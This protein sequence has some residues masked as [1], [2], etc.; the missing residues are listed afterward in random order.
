MHQSYSDRSASDSSSIVSISQDAPD[1]IISGPY[2]AASP[3]NRK[4][5]PLCIRHE[6]SHKLDS[7]HTMNL[8]C[9]SSLP[10]R[11][12]VSF[13]CFPILCFS[14]LFVIL[15]LFVFRSFSS[16]SQTHLDTLNPTSPSAQMPSPSF[17]SS[18]SP[19]SLFTNSR[20]PDAFRSNASL[21]PN[22]RPR[23]HAMNSA[24]QSDP[25]NVTAQERGNAS[26]AMNEVLRGTTTEDIY[27]SAKARASMRAN[28]ESVSNEINESDLQSKNHSEQRI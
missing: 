2:F 10:L 12:S 9:F 11:V 28:S 15:I 22:S 27:V 1:S 5:T 26:P 16:F 13:T 7:E 24:S 19:D 8:V 20:I 18:S 25:A 23:F 21:Q 14:L 3:N 6:I 4:I 17:L